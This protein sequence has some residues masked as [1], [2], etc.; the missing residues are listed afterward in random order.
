MQQISNP[1]SKMPKIEKHHKSPRHS[2][3]STNTKP[4]IVQDQDTRHSYHIVSKIKGKCGLWLPSEIKAKPLRF[5]PVGVAY[6][7]LTFLPDHLLFMLDKDLNLVVDSPHVNH[8]SLTMNVPRSALQRL[9]LYVD[10]QLDSIRV[11]N[12]G[13]M[14]FYHQ[15]MLNR[16]Q[17]VDQWDPEVF[18]LRQGAQAIATAL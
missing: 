10:T 3:M 1:V 18:R 15:E 14:S 2:K 11:P 17:E 13:I 16:L 12:R 4:E 9:I 8:L 6:E 7:V 5:P